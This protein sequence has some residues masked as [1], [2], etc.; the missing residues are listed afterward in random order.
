MAL[1]KFAADKTQKA[2]SLCS[3][4]LPARQIKAL[5]VFV[6][7]SHTQYATEHPPVQ[8]QWGMNLLLLTQH[9]GAGAERQED[10]G[11]ASPQMENKTRDSSAREKPGASS[12]V[13]IIVAC[14]RRVLSP[15]FG[16]GCRVINGPGLTGARRRPARMNKGEGSAPDAVRSKWLKR[17]S[18]HRY[19]CVSPGFS[20]RERLRW[21]LHPREAWVSGRLYTARQYRALT[22]PLWLQSNRT[23]ISLHVFHLDKVEKNQ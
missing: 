19:W 3:G 17:L 20:W 11:P 5:S 15:A 18:A 4:F 7:R 14:A 6:L 9:V 23:G 10:A 8:H 22:S 1:Q 2:P 21:E 16:S 12:S 13:S